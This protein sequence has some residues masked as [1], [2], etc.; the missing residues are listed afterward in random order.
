MDNETSN[1]KYI[2]Y[3]KKGGT[4]FVNIDLGSF[5]LNEYKNLLSGT[6]NLIGSRKF[7]NLYYKYLDYFELNQSIEYFSSINYIAII[8]PIIIYFIITISPIIF[9]YKSIYCKK[10]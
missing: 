9:I 2:N 3:I 6:V 1:E 4:Y 7:T 5:I 8:I 10:I